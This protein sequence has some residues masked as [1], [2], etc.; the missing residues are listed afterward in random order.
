MLWLPLSVFLEIPQES[1]YIQSYLKKSAFAVVGKKQKKELK[2]RRSLLVKMPDP[3]RS[4]GQEVELPNV[5]HFTHFIRHI[6]LNCT[7]ILF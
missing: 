6:L 2:G 5:S 3:G 1:R 4:R 7:H